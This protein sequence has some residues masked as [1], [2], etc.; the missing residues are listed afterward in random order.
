MIGVPAFLLIALGAGCVFSA[1]VLVAAAI[2]RPWIGALIERAVIAVLIAFFALV[3][4]LV[5]YD[6]ELGRQIFST[7]E[8]RFL[9]RGAAVLLF[10]VPTVWVMLY[11][12]GRLG[13]DG[14]GGSNTR[15]DG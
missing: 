2:R 12:T 14:K 1:V 11:L 13:D 9:V 3:Y 6:T 7:E 15:G 5:A 10:A 4:S 8:A